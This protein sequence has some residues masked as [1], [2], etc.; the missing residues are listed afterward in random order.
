MWWTNK[1]LGSNICNHD[2]KVVNNMDVEMGF[3]Y[4]LVMN[5]FVGVTDVY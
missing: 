3:F 1:D 5:Q 2:L 4:D